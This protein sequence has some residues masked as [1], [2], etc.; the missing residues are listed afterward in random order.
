MLGCV[1]AG[2]LI[3]LAAAAYRQGWFVPSPARATPTPIK[4]LGEPRVNAEAIPTPM[5]GG[6]MWIPGGVFWMGSE[7]FLDAVP[8]RKVYVD[9]FWMDKTEVTNAEFQRFVEATGYVTV[10]ERTRHARRKRKRWRP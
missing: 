10:A 2:I 6:M 9:G 3:G 5:P 4:D 8:V 7:Q 1:L